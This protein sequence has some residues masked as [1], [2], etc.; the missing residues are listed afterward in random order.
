MKK[1]NVNILPPLREMAEASATE[2]LKCDVFGFGEVAVEKVLETMI[3][4]IFELNR[5]IIIS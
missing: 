4:L 5:G 1:I 2:Q 3:A